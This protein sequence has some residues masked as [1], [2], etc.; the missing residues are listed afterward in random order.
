MILEKTTQLAIKGFEAYSVSREGEVYSSYIGRFLNKTDNGFGYK[1]VRLIDK[2][3]IEKKYKPYY[4]HR[5]VAEAFLPN[6]DNHKYVGHK[7]HNKCNNHVDNLYWT[8]A[9]TNTK[10][11]VRDSKINYKGRYVN[12]MVR[13]PKEK[14]EA[15]YKEV[16]LGA[17]VGEVSRKYNINRTTLSSWINKR[18]LKDYTDIWDKEI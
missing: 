18:S 5:L 2:S 13:H 1:L 15:A 3:Y 14:Q 12:G 7:D 17:G 8:S 4:V 16:K 6:P 11:G 9:S 10:D